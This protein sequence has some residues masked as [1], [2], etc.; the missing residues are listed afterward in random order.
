LHHHT[1]TGL[2]LIEPTTPQSCISSK[3]IS[4]PPLELYQISLFHVK[5]T[6]FGKELFLQLTDNE[7]GIHYAF[8]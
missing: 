6:P 5:F 3:P 8:S 1:I 2:L 7:D 4:L